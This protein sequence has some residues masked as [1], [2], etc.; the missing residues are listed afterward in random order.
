[1]HSGEK[2]L[3][4]LQLNGCGRARGA[5]GIQET[6]AGAGAPREPAAGEGPARSEGVAG[7]RVQEPREV[8]QLQRGRE[9]MGRK[10][11]TAGGRGGAAGRPAGQAFQGEERTHTQGFM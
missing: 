9:E 7:V 5:L 8:L 2:R 3:A 6:R 11:G 4:V 10:R 1:M